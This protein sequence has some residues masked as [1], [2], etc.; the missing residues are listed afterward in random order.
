MNLSTPDPRNGRVWQQKL[1]GS[2]VTDVNT[3]SRAS[4]GRCAVTAVTVSI[5]QKV[6]YEYFHGSSAVGKQAQ[7]VATQL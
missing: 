6:K 3:A 7:S 5:F 2:S 4:S 1:T